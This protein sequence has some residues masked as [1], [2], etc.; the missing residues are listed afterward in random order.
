MILPVCGFD[1][2]WRQ[3]ARTGEC[4]S[5][6]VFGI[7]GICYGGIKLETMGRTPHQKAQARASGPAQTFLFRVHL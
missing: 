7:A 4:E 3:L 6:I 1:A 5:E 2:A